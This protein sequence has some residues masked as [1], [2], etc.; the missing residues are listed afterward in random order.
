MNL[1]LKVV[2]YLGIGY[3]GI[4]YFVLACLISVTIDEILPEVEQNNAD[5]IISGKD[6]AFLLINIWLIAGMFVCLRNIIPMVPFPL[7]GMYG[8]HHQS[9]K[10]TSGA[11]ISGYVMALSVALLQ[12]NFQKRCIRFA[13]YIRIIWK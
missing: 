1:P 12:T 13:N 6:F 7:D 3:V 2:Q 4:L 5:S 10:E 8:Y 9:M 11:F